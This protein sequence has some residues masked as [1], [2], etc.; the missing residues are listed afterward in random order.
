MSARAFNHSYR[1]AHLAH[2]SFPLGGIGA[3]ML[4]LEG[5]GALGSI[6]VRNK[7]ALLFSPVIFAALY[8]RGRRAQAKVLEGPVPPARWPRGLP[9]EVRG[10]ADGLPR[11]ARAVFRARF[12]FATVTLTDPD[13]PVRVRVTGWSPFVPGDADASSLPVAALEYRITNTGR[14]RLNTVFSFH[15]ENFMRVGAAGGDA[16]CAAPDGFVLSQNG[17]ADAPWEQGAFYVGVRDS[18]PLVDHTWFRGGWFDS[19]TMLWRAIA[20]GTTPSR[21]PVVAGTPSPGGSIYLPLELAAGEE[22]VVPVLLAWYV[23][24]SDVQ[25]LQRDVNGNPCTWGLAHPYYQPW[26]AGQFT[27]IE[28]LVRYWREHYAVLR[29]RTEKFTRCFYDTTLPPEVIEAVAANLTILKS[30]TVLRQTDGRLWAWEGTSANSGCCHGSCTHVWN[31]A[32]ALPHLFP[33]LERSLRETEFFDNQDERGHQQFRADLPIHPQADHHWHAA[34]DGQLGGIMKVYREWRI[35]GDTAWLRRLWPRVRQSLEYCIATWDPN[36]TGVII[37][38]HHNTYD[39][40]FW[41]VDGMHMTLYCGALAAARAMANALGEPAAEY[42]RLHAACRRVLERDLFNGEYFEQHVVWRGLRAGHPAQVPS[43]ATAYSEDALELLQ[44]EGPKYQ[45]GTGC[46]SDG[47]FG[48][49]LAAMCGV[50]TG[51][52]PAKLRAH[53]RAVFRHNFKASLRHHANPQRPHFALGDEAGLLLCTWPR[54]S[55]P[56]LPFP[57]S[58]EVWTGIEY[59]VASHLILL[60]CVKEGLQIVRAARARYDGRVRNPFNEFECGS[61]YARALSSYGLLQS[62]TGARYDAVDKT[63]YLSPR[64]QGDFRAFL[65]TATGYGTVGIKHGKPFLHVREGHIDVQHIVRT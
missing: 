62:L 37:E 60:N 30:P 12:P 41:G 51:V 26:Y 27:S 11:C 7:P 59:Q 29:A 6:S 24:F 47:V 55:E 17:R 52:A 31:Y 63:L 8:L 3:G 32:Q 35:S 53:L 13:W 43:I 9:G 20:T 34:A 56:S 44:N 39:V 14:R 64:L 19:L 48:A 54:G 16:V 4:C 5:T 49:W 50:D 38:P 42:E 28:A 33:A 22:R 45:Y 10:R 2:I 36:R 25:N 57:Y 46:L 1:G 21:P 18:T 40:E 15:A 61:W 23:P 65:C 58:N